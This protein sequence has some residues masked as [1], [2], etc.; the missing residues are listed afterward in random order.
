MVE[1]MCNTLSRILE[2]SK[3]GMVLLT[4]SRICGGVARAREAFE[5]VLRTLSWCQS[6]LERAFY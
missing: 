5:Q 3:V 1:G 4:I 2:Y 6:I